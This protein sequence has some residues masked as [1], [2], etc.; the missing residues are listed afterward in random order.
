MKL[1]QV[2]SA[3]ETSFGGPP[4]VVINS[5]RHLMKQGIDS[6]LLVV[7]QRHET[8]H[9]NQNTKDLTGENIHLFA[10][11]KSGL[12]GKIL[13][14]EEIKKFYRLV[15]D[16]DCVLTH[17]LYNFQNLYLVIITKMLNK[18]Y[19]VMPHGTLTNYQKNQHRI[20]KFIVDNLFFKKVIT[21]C[22]AI[23]VATNSEKNQLDENVKLK[24]SNIG[25]GIERVEIDRNE[26]ALPSIFQFIYIGRLAEVKRVDLTIKAFAKFLMHYPDSF[27]RIVGDGDP[28]LVRSLKTLVTDLGIN[29]NIDF[30]GWI[31]KDD[32]HVLFNQSDFVVLNSEKENFAVGIAEGQAFGLPALV[33]RHVAFS[34]IVEFYKSGIIVEHLNTQAIA[35]GMI[36]IVQ[37][38]Y[39]ELSNNSLLAAKSITWPLV[40]THWIHLAEKV[41]AMKKLDK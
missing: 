41:I 21:N 25:I 6:R 40:I 26:I 19:I 30:T 9:Q 29:D 10:S 15:R 24:A 5:H 23:A 17:Q 11:R 31:E 20:R 22:D 39:A 36:K 28:N 18:P 27:L 37:M 1:L 33:T 35:E 32:K 34:E 16:S 14:I 7:G 2:T 8:F 3:L 13:K 4:N 12:H 38:N